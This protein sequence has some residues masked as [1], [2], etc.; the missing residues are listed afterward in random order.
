MKLKKLVVSCGGTGGHFYPGLSLAREF[1]EKYGEV[2]LLLSG[3]HA[4]EQSRIAEKSGIRA[5][6]LPSMPHYRKNPF[7]FI[8]GF[9]GG[10]FAARRQLKEF[11]PQAMLGMGS[12][13]TLPVVLAAKSCRIPLFLHDG[14]ARVGRAN[15]KFSKWAGFAGTAFPAVNA[16]ECRCPVLETGMPLRPELL[17]S[18]PA[19]KAAAVEAVNREFSTVFSAEKPLF[20]ITG[21]SQGA[22]V[23][24]QVLPEAL[25]AL[26]GEF[27][28]IHLC[29]KGKLADAQKG[30]EKARFPYL[31]QETTGKMAEVMAACDLAFSR[32]GGSTAA[33]LAFFGVPSVLIPYP[34]AAEGHQMDNARHFESH[35][36]AIVVENSQLTGERVQEII[37]DYLDDP[38]KFLEMGRQM[39]YLSRPEASMRMIE[40]ISAH[41]H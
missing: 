2:L 9:L 34:Y 13:A 14:N 16:V 22:A 38:E 27:Q 8:S 37:R 25:S 23:F 12:F 28:V 19:D 21:G 30:Y 1:Q 15:R 18:A 4:V 7:R 10:Y 6:A 29:G 40:R 33:E 11:L 17:R 35:G 26:P 5:V 3:A 31:L 24:N 36:A 32:S 20:L 41:L 39:K